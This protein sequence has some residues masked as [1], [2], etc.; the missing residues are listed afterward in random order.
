[1]ERGLLQTSYSK[2]ELNI[3]TKQ[4]INIKPNQW[5]KVMDKPFKLSSI[6]KPKLN[7]TNNIYSESQELN[8]LLEPKF[9]DLL[10]IKHRDRQ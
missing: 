10:T 2:W 4:A 5:I 6:K 3:S 8:S 1:M 7:K 9:N